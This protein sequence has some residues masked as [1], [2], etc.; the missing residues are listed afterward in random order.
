[1]GKLEKYVFGEAGVWNLLF[2][3]ILVFTAIGSI[4]FIYGM[5]LGK[6]SGLE[7]AEVVVV[8]DPEGF[9]FLLKVVLAILFLGVWG[10]FEVGRYVQ[11]EFTK[12][13]SRKQTETPP[14]PPPPLR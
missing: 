14:P 10:G 4:L 5:V 2:G 13:K 12:R 6:L 7:E 11:T 9:L 8:T 3:V 1:M